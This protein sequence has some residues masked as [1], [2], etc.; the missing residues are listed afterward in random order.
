MRSRS[1]LRQAFMLALSL[2]QLGGVVLPVAA[3][4]RDVEDSACAHP[5]KFSQRRRR[6]SSRW[7]LGAVAKNYRQCRMSRR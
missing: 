1:F 4:Q 2:P 3:G 6:E 5:T 7:M